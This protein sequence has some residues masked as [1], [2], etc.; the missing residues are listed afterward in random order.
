MAAKTCS[1]Q[2]FIELFRSSGAAAT[3]RKLGVGVRSVQ[4][5]RRRI[6]DRTR[7]DITAPVFAPAV[8][9]KAQ[10]NI[11]VPDG[12][13]LVGSDAHYWPGKET[14]MMRAFRTFLGTMQ[15]KV[16]ILNG[17]VFDGAAISRW[18]SVGFLER[19]PEVHEELEACREWLDTLVEASGDARLFWTLGNH[20]LRFETFFAAH[21]LQM[22]GVK[23]VHLKDHFPAW[24]PAWSLMIN[25]DVWVKHDCKGGKHATYL[26]SQASGKSTVT[27]HLH[28]ANVRP[29]TDLNGTRYGV[30][31]G[32]M[33]DPYDE[34]FIHYTRANVVDWRSAFVVLT[35]RNGRLMQPELVLKWSDDAVEFRGEVVRVT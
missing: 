19:K 29:I 13:V 28:S 6:E 27:G 30:D 1:D 2:E 4:A 25:Q 32:M 18:P 31:T 7:Q 3:A 26:N 15:P 11:R 35:F 14:V 17:D 9:H 10:V 21:A 34:Q 16:V 8:E 33:G 5:R 22:K 20:D 24:T 12:V 23:G